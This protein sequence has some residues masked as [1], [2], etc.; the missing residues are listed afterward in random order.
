MRILQV[1]NR[2]R[3]AGGEDMVVE[4]ERALLRAGGHEVVPY[5]VDNPASGPDAARAMV[6]S[7]W[8]AAAAR[9]LAEVA[10]LHRP[11]VVHVHNT[12]FALSP[13]VFGALSGGGWPTVATLHNFRTVCVNGLLLRDNRICHDCVG[14]HPWAA[15]RHRCYRD[16]AP[17]S[18]LAALTIATARRRKVW[19]RD[20]TLFLVLEESARP[21]LTESG[22]PD[23]RVTVQ[24]NFVPDPGPR[25]A[26]PSAG[27][28]V[29][30]VG[31]LS[32]EKGPGV[33]LEAWRRAAP[34]RLGLTVYGDGPLRRQLEARRDPGVTFA[35]TVGH[36]ELVTALL[37]ARALVFPSVCHEG[38]PLAPLEAAGAGLPLL[39]SSSVGMAPRMVAAGAGWDAP[40]G[41]VDALG[42]GLARLADPAQVDAAGAAARQLYLGRHSP[43]AAL[44]SLEAVYRRAVTRHPDL[45]GQ[46]P[47]PA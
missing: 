2:H 23:H 47:G 35:G 25:P 31:R 3:L 26:P 43:Q 37:S 12:W 42:E 13:S 32:E 45:S 19:E 17:L 41:D 9:H 15:V 24:P 8:N 22:I 1:H 11:D 14:T 33:L 18:A 34:G 16:S 27:D 10:R 39:M 38:G 36:D 6:T 7:P 5:V 4:N 28:Q 30:M 40:P 21:L 20:V 46:A 29:V 44:A